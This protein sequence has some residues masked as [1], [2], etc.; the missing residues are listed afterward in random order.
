MSYY[1]ASETL[2]EL[3]GIQISHMTIGKISDEVAGAIAAKQEHCPAFQAALRSV[4]QSAT[5]ET[6]F[7][8][9][10]TCIHIRNADGTTEWREVKVGAFVKRLCG[11]PAS[12]WEWAT[13]KLP[14]P[15]AVSAFAAIE[16][17]ESFLER[18]QNE[19]RRLGVGGVTSALGDGAVWIWNLIR[20]L[21]GKTDECLDIYHA[22]EHVADC[23]KVLYGTGQSFKDW[24]ERVRL[25]LLSEG[26]AGMER[27][28][29][30]LLQGKLKKAQREAVEALQK[31]LCKNEGRLHY[32]ERL[33]AGRSIGSGLI[34]GACKNL[35][36]KRMKQTG[37][38]WKIDR[39]NK[40]A[41]L[42]AA[43]YADNW[44]IAWKK[45]H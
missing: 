2:E 43:L 39:A 19:R 29:K 15:G 17:K 40:I 11:L 14:P 33:A 8:T 37:A 12:P 44:K 31:Y 32:A 25:V 3:C 6:E 38:C 23:G 9:D 28:L 13:R 35:V 24:L 1:L 20:E 30:S 41:V 27:E 36:G 42:A 45:Y 26:F 7:L 5:G 21:F 16:N 22:L 4:F 18:C 34:E 10:G